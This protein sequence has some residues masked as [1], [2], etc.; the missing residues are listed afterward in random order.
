M[1]QGCERRLRQGAYGP[2]M[3]RR[4]DMPGSRARPRQWAPGSAVLCVSPDPPALPAH[5]TLGLGLSSKAPSRQWVHYRG[6]DSPTPTAA[7]PAPQPLLKM[8]IAPEGP[9]PLPSVLCPQCKGRQHSSPDPGSR[10]RFLEAVCAC[11][12]AIKQSGLKLSQRPPVR[13]SD[14]SKAEAGWANGHRALRWGPGSGTPAGSEPR[15]RAKVRAQA[16]HAPASPGGGALCKGSG[17]VLARARAGSGLPYLTEYQLLAKKVLARLNPREAR[18]IRRRHAQGNPHGRWPRGAAL[19]EPGRGR[20][21]GQ[22]GQRLV[23]HREGGA[24][25]LVREGGE[26]DGQRGVSRLERGGRRGGQESLVR[27]AGR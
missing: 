9:G 25:G 5:P 7:F 8:A 6:T 3:V 13:T 1:S 18:G 20:G 24:G 17:S 15:G 26:L 22:P 4:L 11:T 16:G 10:R 21:Q 27:R 12:R 14:R 19:R 23:V 2:H